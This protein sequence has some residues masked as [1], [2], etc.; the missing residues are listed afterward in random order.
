MKRIRTDTRPPE[1]SNHYKLWCNWRCTGFPW[2]DFLH[3]TKHISSTKHNPSE[4]KTFVCRPNLVPKIP[5]YG[6]C[7]LLAIEIH[8]CYF[9]KTQPWTCSSLHDKLGLN[10]PRTGEDIFFLQVIKYIWSTVSWVSA[11]WIISKILRTWFPYQIRWQVIKY[12]WSKV[13]TTPA[14]MR[15]GN[16]CNT[17][18]SFY[19]PLHYHLQVEANSKKIVQKNRCYF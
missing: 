3:I 12:I 11:T 1:L 2:R 4:T 13:Y 8:I 18:H 19:F 7:L 15:W 10:R 17:Q 6:S 9:T 16:N 5:I 14:R